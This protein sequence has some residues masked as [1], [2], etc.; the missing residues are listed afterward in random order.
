VS[1]TLDPCSGRAPQSAA[2]PRLLHGDPPREAGR[3]A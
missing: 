2:Q 3:A 1:G